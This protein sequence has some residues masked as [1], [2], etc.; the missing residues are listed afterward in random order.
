MIRLQDYTPEIYYKQSRDFQVLGRLYDVVLNSVKTNSDSLYYLPIADS[1]MQTR[2]LDLLAYTLGFTAKHQYSNTQL[3]AVCS[4]F[5]SLLKLKGSISAI[6]LLGDTLLSSEGITEKF[7]CTSDG[8]VLQL[9]VPTALSSTSL[10]NDLLDYLLPAGMTCNI[11]RVSTV[12][13]SAVTEINVAPASVHLFYDSATEKAVNLTNLSIIPSLSSDDTENAQYISDATL[14]T[15]YTGET[16]DDGEVEIVPTKAMAA[17][18][19]VLDY[20]RLSGVFDDYKGTLTYYE[21]SYELPIKVGDTIYTLN[22]DKLETFGEAMEVSHNGSTK[23]PISFDTG[24]NN[25]VYSTKETTQELTLLKENEANNIPENL[26]VIA[27][28][29]TKLASSTFRLPEKNIFEA[30]YTDSVNL[31]GYDLSI[32]RDPVD[33][34]FTLYPRSTLDLVDV[35]EGN[36]TPYLQ[37]D[38]KQT[39]ELRYADDG[40][41]QMQS[42]ITEPATA[43]DSTITLGT[44]A[45]GAQSAGEPICISYY[46]NDNDTANLI[47]TNEL[48]QANNLV[49]HTVITDINEKVYPVYASY[50]KDVLAASIKLPQLYSTYTSLGGTEQTTNTTFNGKFKLVIRPV[51]GD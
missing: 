39:I 50:F 31:L 26:Y 12:S 17:N 24:T 10:L 42:L 47:K 15:R 51:F 18:S 2:M 28:V 46:Y 38:N 7:S 35:L 43:K 49:Q 40:S 25:I 21:V 11:I 4:I 16:D 32:M 48:L 27:P 23:I 19:A 37:I 6:Q 34:N 33:K 3:A 1:T 44:G 13:L 41:L 45:T 9:Y 29:G 8:P 5:S 36:E 22:A 20:G 14:Y 30:V